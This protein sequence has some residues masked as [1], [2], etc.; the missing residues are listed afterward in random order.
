ML[1]FTSCTNNYIP[2]A[3]V[4]AYSLKKFHPKWEFCLLLGETPPKQFNIKSE[5]FDRI[6]LFSDLPIQALSLLAFPP[7]SC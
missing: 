2:K 5:P 1:I 4:L 6:L 7:S 3:R